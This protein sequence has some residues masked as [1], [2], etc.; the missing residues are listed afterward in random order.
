LKESSLY[1]TKRWQLAANCLKRAAKNFPYGLNFM[2]F[3][4]DLNKI[5]EKNNQI[6]E[7]AISF[8][9]ADNS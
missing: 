8:I 3:R 1:Q 9:C 6:A 4:K 7:N 5:A 2:A